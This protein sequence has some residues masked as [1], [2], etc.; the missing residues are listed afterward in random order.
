MSKKRVHIFTFSP[1]VIEEDSDTNPCHEKE[2]KQTKTV[3]GTYIGMFPFQ[4]ANLVFYS[5]LHQWKVKRLL[6][7]L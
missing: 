2:N 5:H 1:Q 7:S 3:I 4:K 6:L